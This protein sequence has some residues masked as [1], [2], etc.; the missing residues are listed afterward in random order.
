MQVSALPILVGLIVGLVSGVAVLRGANFFARGDALSTGH[1]AP[2]ILSAAAVIGGGAF[3]AVNSLTSWQGWWLALWGEML[4]LFATIDLRSRRVPN[5]LVLT[6]AIVA[7]ALSLAGFGPR[8]LNSLLGG[9]VGL[10]IFFALALV[11]RG[12]MGMG[13]VKFA[14]LVGL[15]TG[16]PGVLA[17]L[18]AGVIAG[19]LGALILLLTRRVRRKSFIPYVPFLAAGAWLLMAYAAG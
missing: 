16:Y 9:V 14:G 3:Y 17:A 7:V 1:W 2:A 13:D 11:Q 18:T 15:L 8:P 5:V 19:G 6:A 4:L 10:A 12:A